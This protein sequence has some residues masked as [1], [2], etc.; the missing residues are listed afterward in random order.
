MSATHKYY[1]T[2]F[3]ITSKGARPKREIIAIENN[4]VI[5]SCGHRRPFANRERV[6]GFRKCELCQ[7]RKA[8]YRKNGQGKGWAIDR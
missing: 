2:A 8:Y 5:L 1:K 7:D 6:G 4:E 3:G